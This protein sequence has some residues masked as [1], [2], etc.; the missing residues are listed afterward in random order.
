MNGSIN[1][2]KDRCPKP[3]YIILS[4]IFIGSLSLC[5]CVPIPNKWKDRE[6]W[7]GTGVI[8]VLKKLLNCT[9]R[10]LWTC[11]KSGIKRTQKHSLRLHFVRWIFFIN[12]LGVRNIMDNVQVTM[13]ISTNLWPSTMGGRTRTGRGVLGLGH[14]YIYSGYKQVS[15]K[16]GVSIWF[17]RPLVLVDY[18][19]LTVLIKCV[20]AAQPHR[21]FLLSLPD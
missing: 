2:L 12:L 18:L 8:L 4:L 9:N 19:L 1:S 20:I 11:K 21:G 16:L 6:N 10:W 7:K 15:I 3:I 13:L 14:S 17:S 5:L